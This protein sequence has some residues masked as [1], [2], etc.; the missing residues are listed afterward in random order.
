MTEP[1]ESL[2]KLLSSLHERA[3]ELNCLYR[4]EEILN[5]PQLSTREM[6]ERIVRTIPEGWQYPDVCRARIMYENLVFKSEDWIESPWTMSAD[7]IVIDEYVGRDRGLQRG[8]AAGR[9]RPVPQG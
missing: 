6:I 4:I 2:G 8:E 3:K 1:N 5:Q 9:R 7:I